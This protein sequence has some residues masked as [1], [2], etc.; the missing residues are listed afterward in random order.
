MGVAAGDSGTKSAIAV[1]V[2]HPTVSF[3]EKLYHFCP[4]QAEKRWGTRGIKL[5]HLFEME[6][7]GWWLKAMFYRY[8]VSMIRTG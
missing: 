6:V 1:F 2:S 4:E 3:Y 8:Q 5:C 7:L